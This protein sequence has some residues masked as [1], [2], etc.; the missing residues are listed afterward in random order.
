MAQIRYKKIFKDIWDADKELFQKFFL[1]NNE[2]E[3]VKKR[4]SVEDEFQN[5][6]KQVKKL[7]QEGEQELCRQMEKSQHRVFSSNLADKYWDEIRQYFKY[8]DMVGVKTKRV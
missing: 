6:G 3:D 2:Y 5:I 7:L 8:M 4:A 1:L